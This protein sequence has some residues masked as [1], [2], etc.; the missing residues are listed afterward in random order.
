MLWLVN[1]ERESGD[2]VGMRAD[3][4]EDNKYKYEVFRK[5]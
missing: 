4:K 1:I 5:E 3:K 2:K